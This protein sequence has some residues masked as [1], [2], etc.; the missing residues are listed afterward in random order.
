MTIQT[1]K[2]VEGTQKMLDRK[3]AEHESKGWTLE[4]TEKKRRGEWNKRF[5]Y[6]AY[7]KRQKP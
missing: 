6:I 5:V 2:L 3:I 1:K 7:L 4:R